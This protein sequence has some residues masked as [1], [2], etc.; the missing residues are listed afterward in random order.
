MALQILCCVVV[1]WLLGG[2]N[3]AIVISR[4]SLH[5]DVRTKGSGNAGLTNFYRAYGGWKT[6]LVVFID[7]GKMVAAC[8]LA[9]LLLPEKPQLAMMIAGVAV[10][11]GHVFPVFF[12]FHGGKGILCSG[13]LAVVMDWRIAAIAF[14]AFLVVFFATRLVSLASIV[15][16]LF[17]AGLFM[18]FFWEQPCI[19]ILAIAMALLAIF[20]HR[21]NIKRL[22]R[23]EEHRM[24]FRKNKNV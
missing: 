15:A 14:P 10:Q 17:Y 1:G 16:I 23:G 9:R 18:L 22:L 20:M 11:I 24:Q 4:L 7:I 12:G 19:W 6:L 8:L 21:G 3:G 2:L 5:E 13:A